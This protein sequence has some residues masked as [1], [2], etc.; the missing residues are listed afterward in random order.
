MAN[1]KRFNIFNIKFLVK[2]SLINIFAFS[3]ILFL[4][5]FE[6]ENNWKIFIQYFYSA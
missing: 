6:K 4:K 5:K 2:S 1:F 3:Q